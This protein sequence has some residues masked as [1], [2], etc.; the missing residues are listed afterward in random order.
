MALRKKCRHDR[1][2]SVYEARF[3]RLVVFLSNHFGHSLTDWKEQQIIS[4]QC[5]IRIGDFDNI[6]QNFSQL[7]K[8]GLDVSEKSR[9]V[10]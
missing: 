1:K 9:P 8:S 5:E 2:Y 4:V 10:I 3:T 6:E 7:H